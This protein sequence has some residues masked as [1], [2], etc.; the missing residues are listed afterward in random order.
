MTRRAVVIPNSALSRRW[1]VTWRHAAYAILSFA[2][3]A[4]IIVVPAAVRT[5]S[6]AT[7]RIAPVRIIGV[8]ARIPF[9]TPLQP[10][11]VYA[12]VASS[13][14]TAWAAPAF[15]IR[16]AFSALHI[17]AAFGVSHGPARGANKEKREYQ[18]L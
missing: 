18:S 15:I 11:F 4:T 9:C 6:P 8:S 3:A 7:I 10:F 14:L 1:H 12:P 16:F 5:F 17:R 13:I 2:S